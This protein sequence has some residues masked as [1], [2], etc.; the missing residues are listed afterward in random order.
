[1]WNRVEIKERGK[2]AMKAN[3]WRSVLAAF[4][5]SVLAGGSAVMS[6]TR[7][8]NDPEGMPADEPMNDAAEAFSNIPDDQAGVAGFVLLGFLIAFLVVMAV[9]F[10]LKIFVFNPLQVGCY[11]FFRENAK[12]LHPNLD[13]LKSGFGNYG[14][15]FLTLLLR[16]VF[17][18]LWAMLFIIP[19]IIKIYSYRMVPFILR[20]R[21]DLSAREVITES[22]MLMDGNKWQTFL[23]DLSYIGWCLLGCVT[24]GLVN[25]FWTAPYRQNA[26]ALLYLKLIGEDNV[27]S[28]EP[29]SY[30][31]SNV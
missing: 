4:L 12:G 25:I 2:I 28:G 27:V 14:H 16:D 13:V 21:P 23:F 15:T 29:V 30:P 6:G 9:A 11:G 31:V 10:V 1:M 17:T 5:I 19:G 24:L 7:T 22:R 26:N 20:D 3:Y 18:F 8:D